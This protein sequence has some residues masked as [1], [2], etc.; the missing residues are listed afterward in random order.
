MKLQGKNNLKKRE[1]E[2]ATFAF[3]LN[4]TV[5]LQPMIQVHFVLFSNPF[6]EFLIFLC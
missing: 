5:K 3:F 4:A 2:I 6:Q 1:Y